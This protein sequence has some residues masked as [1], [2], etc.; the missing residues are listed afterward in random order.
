MVQFA[1]FDGRGNVTAGNSVKC[2]PSVLYLKTCAWLT[3]QNDVIFKFYNLL[4][5][6]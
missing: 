1:G 2:T 3:K 4:A 6:Q 5:L